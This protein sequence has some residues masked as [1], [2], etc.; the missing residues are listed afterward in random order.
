MA[1]PLGRDRPRVAMV[2]SS[3]AGNPY[4][5]LLEDALTATDVE[6]LPYRFLDVVS[7][8]LDVLHLHWP[9]AAA[10][11]PLWRAVLRS[12][13]LLVLVLT[14]R[15]RRVTLIW[16]VHN[17]KSHEVTHPRLEESL[18]RVLARLV[19]GW[20]AMSVEAASIIR[21]Q[22]P[23]L[24]RF[25]GRVIPHGHYRGYYEQPP[26]QEGAR[27]LLGIP[28]EAKVILFFGSI[29]PY[30]NVPALI[31]AFSSVPDAN[32]R[33]VIAGEL[34]RWET[35]PIEDLAEADQRIILRPQRVPDR[36]VPTLFATADLCVLPFTEILNSGS[37]ILALSMN[38]P[39]L[40]P[41]LG[42]LMSLHREVGE[43]WVQLYHGELFPSA[44]ED[45]MV[46]ASL[47]S[48]EPDFGA[49]AW[50]KIGW[51]TRQMYV[52]LANDRR[53]HRGDRTR[54][55]RNRGERK[56]TR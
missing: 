7:A 52:D 56:S 27:E 33:L 8:H 37:A 11:G 9:E 15:A 1:S 5:R 35:T 40:A 18:R 46:R 4:V 50:E 34:K 20:I 55:S 10:K 41:S 44:L 6:C 13:K 14:A 38:T 12:S 47:V 25:P 21:E 30:K 54:Q 53:L 48:G 19:D 28:L 23:D 43:P 3:G 42:S 26:S 51:A 2:Y 16:T 24:L 39:I 31:R 32:W 49:I 45:A 36:D 17:V 29:R 22:L